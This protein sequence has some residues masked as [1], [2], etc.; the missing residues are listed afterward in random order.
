MAAPAA[1][2][3]KA[4]DTAVKHA[5]HHAAKHAGHHTSKPHVPVDSMDKLHGHTNFAQL[6]ASSWNIFRYCGDYLH[7]FGVFVLVITIA[8]N[9]S[10]TGISRSTQILY[11]LVFM[12]RYL[13]LLDHRQTAYLVFFKM[14]YIISSML[15]LVLF[16][17]LDTT[18]ERRLDTANLAVIIVPCAVAAL[19]LTSEYS[20]LELCWTFSEF[21]E[22]FAMVPQYVFCYRDRSNRDLGAS[23]YIIALGGYRV[24]YALNWIYKKYML[25]AYSDYQSW[26][27]GIIEI[28][29]FVDFLNYRFTGNSFLRSM[30]LKVD[31]KINEIS[32]K[33][34]LKVL[35]TTRTE[36]IETDGGEMRRRRKTDEAEASV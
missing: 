25:P 6:A 4:V 29:F 7:L 15:V 12:T 36:R 10:V 5:A 2:A 13:D 27:G 26:I 14:A 11:F 24:F 19:L 20:V 31:T 8:K 3:V 23:V 21:I 34:E 22:G 35:G 1:E 28:L 32:D 17:Q 30:V 18:Y 9:K 16:L 33:V